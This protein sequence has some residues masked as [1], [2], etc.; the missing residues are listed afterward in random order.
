M[1]KSDTYIQYGVPS[2]KAE[3]YKQLDLPV[4][5]FRRTS[6][7]NLID[8]YSLD[9][10]EVD[11]V[12]LCI[13][14]QPIHEDTVNSLLENNNY[15][16][17][18]CKGIKS[19]AYIIHH[20]E[21]YSTSQDNNYH[22]LAVLCPND[23]DLVHRK[24]ARLTKS[25][26]KEQV[27]K[28]KRKW[29]NEV[30]EHN[31]VAAS[32]SGEASEIDFVNIPRIF[33]LCLQIFGEIPDN[34]YSQMLKGNKVLTETGLINDEYLNKT[35][36][37]RKSP[38]HFF[39]G[40][41]GPVALRSYMFEIMKQILRRVEFVD[42]DSLLKRSVLR[43]TNIVGTYCFY[44]GGVY[45]KAPKY[46]VTRDSPVTHIYIR[47]K[48]FFAEWT[49][50]PQYLTSLTARWRIANRTQYLIYGRI[51]GVGE[52]VIKGEKFIHIDIRPYVFGIPTQTKNR[53]PLV[54]YIKNQNDYDECF[55]IDEE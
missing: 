15:T 28:A 24:G 12:K 38:F 54:H 51:R 11:F 32:R 34:R 1:Y 35:F 27:L 52:K 43:S 2:D 5:A 17:C 50:H 8:K 21:E 6:K 40:L 55:M 48:P 26:S 22:N 9:K 19:D 42:L 53:T 18:I 16:C 30:R 47:R 7:K 29:E 20:I 14:R 36:P 49:F 10:Q 3:K 37:D 39:M 31:V 23:H 25:I 4:T 46:P 33:E 44:V 13:S 41:Q 45:G